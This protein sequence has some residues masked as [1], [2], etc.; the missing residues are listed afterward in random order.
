MFG[1]KKTA[2]LFSALAI[3]GL[4]AAGAVAVGPA[5]SASAAG[6]GGSGPIRMAGA[7]RYTTSQVISKSNF[8]TQS[9]AVFL[10]TGATF[11]DALAAG[12]A[13]GLKAS[14][15]LL[16]ASSGLS[17]SAAQE[18]KRLRPATIYVMGGTGAVSNAVLSAARAYSPN[19]VRLSGSDRYSTA[20]S[21]TKK[22]WSTADTV[23]IASGANF[24][25]ALSGGALAAKLKSPILLTSQSG[26]VSATEAELKRLTPTK[27]VILG[28][29]GA[30]SAA[31]EAQIAAAVPGA[32][33]SRIQGAD[34]LATSAAIAKA[35]WGSSAK[36]MYAV[37]WDFPDAL[38]GVAAAAAND[39]PLLLTNASC[40]PQSVWAESQSLG[41]TTKGILG[42][43]GVLTITSVSASCD[44]G[45]PW[46]AASA[47][48]RS[49]SGVG[50]SVISIAKPDG[51]AS[52][53]MATLTHRGT[54][55]FTVTSLDSNYNATKSDMI[56]GRTGDYVGTVI[57]DPGS[58]AGVTAQLAI[59]ASGPWTV[60]IASVKAAPSYAKTKIVGKSDAVFNYSGKAGA[61]QLSSNVSDG[62]AVVTLRM[63]SGRWEP[64]YLIVSQETG[65]YNGTVQW[66][67][68]PAV[69]IVYSDGPWSANIR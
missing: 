32:A 29:T 15:V 58:T 37:A 22:F 53:G 43:Q 61:V 3:S 59:K 56:A 66:P 47:T 49:Y 30:V 51:A 16:T 36:A 27:V 25:D 1:N 62:F 34:R 24:A 6:L 26:L 60:S 39:A 9:E 46:P 20:A 65:H 17:G 19:V 11:P 8:P 23:Y 13:A 2:Q 4:L 48:A 45:G 40:M 7:D 55:D 10:A 31:A 44:E 5:E 12:P 41:V 54:G 28:G 50:D 35:G 18:L 69:G 21:T 67:A 42:G 33:V 57:F 52:V 68:G 64:G 38:A 14:P 63:I